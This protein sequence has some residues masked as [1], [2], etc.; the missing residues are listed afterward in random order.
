MSE[1][2]REIDVRNRALELLRIQ[3][4]QLLA[5]LKELLDCP[6]Q[7]TARIV[8]AWEDARVVVAACEKLNPMV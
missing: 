8:Q 2:A 3:R 1:W 7:D 6:A 5:A 4:D